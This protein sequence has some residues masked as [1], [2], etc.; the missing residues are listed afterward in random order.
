[1]PHRRQEP[2]P[3]PSCV[4]RGG[5]IC[6]TPCVSEPVRT[7]ADVRLDGESVQ[8]G[9]VVAHDRVGLRVAHV[10]GELVGLTETALTQELLVRALNDKYG[11]IRAALGQG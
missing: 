3:T 8:P 5:S 9:G 2:R 11:L 1:M 6:P 4:V 10:G 7:G